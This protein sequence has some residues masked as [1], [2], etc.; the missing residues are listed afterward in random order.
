MHIIIVLYY[1]IILNYFLTSQ[2]D[3]HTLEYQ[4]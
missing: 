4:V 3:F 1:Y 2:F